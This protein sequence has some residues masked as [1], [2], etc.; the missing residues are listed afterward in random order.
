MECRSILIRLRTTCLFNIDYFAMRSKQMRSK[1]MRSKQ[2]IALNRFGLGARVGEVEGIGDPVKWLQAQLEDSPP[3]LVNTPP[4]D[5]EI[6]KVQSDFVQAV[7]SQDREQIQ[8]AARAAVELMAGEA[9]NVL[10]T[11]V[12]SD[13]PFVERWIAFWSN[14]LCVSPAT[15]PRINSLV[16]AY[17]REAIRPHALG[18]FEDMLL[19]SARHPAMLLYLDNTQSVGPN[20]RSLQRNRGRIQRRRTGLNENYARELL[21]LHTVG[22]D[23]GYTQDDVQQLALILTGW[24]LSGVMRSGN[25]PLGYRFMNQFHEPGPKTVLGIRYAEA[26]EAEGIDVIKDLAKRPET[27]RFLSTKLIRHFVDDN[28]PETP[29]KE[30]ARVWRETEGDLKE[31]A[32]TLVQLDESWDE[33]YTKFRTPQDWM[34]AIYRAIGRQQ[35]A[36]ADLRMLRT[37]RHQLWAPSAPKGYEDTM[38]AWADPDSLL[39]RAEAVR[40]MVKRIPQA[41]TFDPS[42][43][44]TVIDTSDNTLLV[45]LL[46]DSSLKPTD[47]VALG[48]ASPSFQWR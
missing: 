15:E 8:P 10:T 18:K 28:P 2:I 17:E 45:D 13:R 23:G 39:N 25:Q 31:I 41:K 42:R 34:V 19:A 20:S 12:V 48:F 36:L 32:S 27:A 43:L 21:E 35:V 37:L 47:R 1:Q 24:S 4:T 14:H 22:V 9:S 26:G 30:L 11:R 40:T 7:L 44:S 16:G 6:K 46:D 5:S 38:K 29:V 33:R 3:P